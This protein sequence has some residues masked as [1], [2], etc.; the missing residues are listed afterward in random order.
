M[1]LEYYAS[2]L[3][4]CIYLLWDAKYFNKY[5]KM[6]RGGGVCFDENIESAG[7]L[8]WAFFMRNKINLPQIY[9]R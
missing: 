5:T 7:G 9:N 6:N 2:T 1:R 8:L 4:I 3:Q